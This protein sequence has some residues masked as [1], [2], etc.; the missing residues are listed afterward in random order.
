MA[1]R[2]ITFLPDKT[3]VSMTTSWGIFYTPG[4]S[5]NTQYTNLTGGRVTV[6][7]AIAGITLGE[8]ENIKKSF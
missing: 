1:D 5:V 8:N 7:F 2:T 4:Q 6:S 3:S